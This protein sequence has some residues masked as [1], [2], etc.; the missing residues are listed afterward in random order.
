M[1]IYYSLKGERDKAE[2][3]FWWVLDKVDEHIP[4]QI[5][6]NPLQVSVSPLL[7]SHAMFI[8]SSKFLGCH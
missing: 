7:W 1:S 3:Y 5:F 6:D 4:E 2:G 8:I